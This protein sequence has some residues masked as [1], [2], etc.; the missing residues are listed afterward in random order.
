MFNI[1]TLEEL[2]LIKEK[3][4]KL[5]N[6]N[7]YQSIANARIR[8][9]GN[10]NCVYYE[11]IKDNNSSILGMAVVKDDRIEIPFGPIIR[12]NITSNDLNDYIMNI[13]KINK[14]SVIFSV[15]KKDSQVFF[16][17][18]SKLEE[19]WFFSTLILDINKNY[20]EILKGYNQNRRRILRKCSE[21]LNITNIYKDKNLY[22]KFFDIYSKRLSETNGFLDLTFEQLK[23][24]LENEETDLYMYLDGI[25]PISGIITFSCGDTVINRYNATNPDFLQLNANSFVENEIIKKLTND[26]KY[27]F[28]DMSGFNTD[29]NN[30][31]GNHINQY[32]LSYGPQ[33]V[34]ECRWYKL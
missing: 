16:P 32:K 19:I 30:E 20:D 18:T 21:I 7:F 15:D 29:E 3:L 14:K 12:G 1:Y 23:L 26:E 17:L 24:I 22:D 13:K 10:K 2:E 9:Y 4:T 28:Y 27:C 6:N 34:K 25:T 31:K 11:F 5:K 8:L 33:I